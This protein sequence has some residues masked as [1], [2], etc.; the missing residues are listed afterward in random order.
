MLASSLHCQSTGSSCAG[1]FQLCWSAAAPCAQLSRCAQSLCPG[2]SLPVLTTLS[3]TLGAEGLL[4]GH[5]CC[6]SELTLALLPTCYQQARV[7]K[8]LTWPRLWV[9]RGPAGS[10][11]GWQWVAVAGLPAAQE[12]CW[13]ELARS[14]WHSGAPPLLWRGGAPAQLFL[15]S[16]LGLA[17]SVLVTASTAA[18][19]MAPAACAGRVRLRVRAGQPGRLM[20][21]PEQQLHS[22]QQTRGRAQGA[23]NPAR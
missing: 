8:G 11:Q 3:L 6:V 5:T 19:S 14:P 20:R 22:Q 17:L 15:R 18:A 16:T 10:Q 21:L 13:R 7:P 9:R 23:R 2:L 12:L 4:C 1:G